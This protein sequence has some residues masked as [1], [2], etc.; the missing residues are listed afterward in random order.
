LPR[1]FRPSMSKKRRTLPLGIFTFRF[2][3]IHPSTPP[4]S[5]LVPLISSPNSPSAL[6]VMVDQQDRAKIVRQLAQG[7]NF[8]GDFGLIFPFFS[9]PAPPVPVSTTIREGPE[10]FQLFFLRRSIVF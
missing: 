9:L 4:V 6:P 5:P 10:R 1:M 2:T 8:V 7:A 3:E